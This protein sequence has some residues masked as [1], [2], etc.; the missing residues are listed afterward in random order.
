MSRTPTEALDKTPAGLD[1]DIRAGDDF[2]DEWLFENDDGSPFDL[3]DHQFGMEV[4]RSAGVEPPIPVHVAVVNDVGGIV[5]LRLDGIVTE[6]MERTYRYD[7]QSTHDGILRTWVAG[8][9]YVEPEI[10]KP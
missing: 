5:T 3:T 8:V 10:T 4:R 6:M 2:V 1:I 9:L 7:L